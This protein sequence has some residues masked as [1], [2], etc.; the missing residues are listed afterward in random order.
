VET[1]DVGAMMPAN[2]CKGYQLLYASVFTYL[3]RKLCVAILK[4]KLSLE[5][6]KK[7]LCYVGPFLC[8]DRY[9]SKYTT[10]LAK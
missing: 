4:I 1:R 3:L 10:T 6:I 2:Q 7:I 5:Q 8:D 9:I